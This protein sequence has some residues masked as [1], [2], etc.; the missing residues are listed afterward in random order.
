MFINIFKEFL[1]EFKYFIIDKRTRLIYARK[2]KDFTTIKLNLGC[3]NKV[4]KDFVNID[5]NKHADLR[6]DLRKIL[7]FNENSVDYIYSEH[8]FEHINYYDYTAINC[9]RDYYRI[10]K[11][12][13]KIRIVIPNM[14]NSFIAYVNRDYEY[15]KEI[16][17]INKLPISKYATLVDYLNLG[18]SI[19][20]HKFN[21]DFEKMNLLL[22]KIGFK[23]I[24]K[25]SFNPK[26]DSHE[27][28]RRKYSLYI[29]AEK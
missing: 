2:L 9:L 15:F 17:E 14:E 22:Y 8:F 27:I 11:K 5:L 21:Y 16:Y 19:F 29:V 25:D 10:L 24:K 6:L 1:K 7:P 26:E 28:V 3:G 20:K 4:K 13:G 18:T 23:D 12:G